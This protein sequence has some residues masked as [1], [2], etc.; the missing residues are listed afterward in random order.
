MAAICL[1]ARSGSASRSTADGAA[2]YKRAGADL[3][4]F[5]GGAVTFGLY[6]AGM[7]FPLAGEKA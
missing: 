6:Q 4:R 7:N 2:I 3:Q 1:A 5:V